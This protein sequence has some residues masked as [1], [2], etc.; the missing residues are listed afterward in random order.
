MSWRT[1][2]VVLLGL[3]AAGLLAGCSSGPA[4]ATV[5][6]EV[7]VNGTPV[8]KG[9][10]S[11]SPAEG[12]GKLVTGEIKNGRYEVQTTAGK[13]VVQISAPVV[14]GKRKDSDAPNAQWV[15]ITEESL[16]DKYN[17]KSELT[18]DVQAGGNTKDWALDVKK[19]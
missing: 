17:S 16:P 2:L 5:S 1:G 18:F 3:C 6:G 7:K 10:I 11:F 9:V 13:K 19:K 15:E 4:S 14:T 12:T 8:E